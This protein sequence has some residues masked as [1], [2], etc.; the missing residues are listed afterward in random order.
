MFRFAVGYACSTCIGQKERLKKK[1]GF[2]PTQTELCNK[3]QN[4]LWLCA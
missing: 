3:M 4:G 2:G 1:Q